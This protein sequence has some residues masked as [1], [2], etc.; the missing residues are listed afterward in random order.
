MAQNGIRVYG[1]C[2]AYRSSQSIVVWARD[3]ENSLF[4]GSNRISRAQA[5]AFANWLL[6]AAK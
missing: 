2:G 4:S 3:K 5:I 1:H 6:K